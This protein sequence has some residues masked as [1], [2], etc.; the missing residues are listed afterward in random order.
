MRLSLRRML[1]A[2]HTVP[3]NPLFLQQPLLFRRISVLSDQQIRLVV[4]IRYGAA[5]RYGALQ[6]PRPRADVPTPAAPARTPFS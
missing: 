4:L 2:G 3:R 1:T 6:T 5:V